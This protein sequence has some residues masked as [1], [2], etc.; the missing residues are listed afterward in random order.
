MNKFCVYCGEKLNSA[1][2][3]CGKCGKAIN[4]LSNSPKNNNILSILGLVFAIISAIFLVIFIA[5]PETESGIEILF[6]IFSGLLSVCG[7]VLS[8]V[9]FSKSKK[10]SDYKRIIS[11]IAMIVNITLFS[12]IIFIFVIVFI[13]FLGDAIFNTGILED[14]LAMNI[15]PFILN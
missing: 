15:N 1:D 13:I 14:L 11:L 6:I 12:F 4:Q 3:F 2:K 5:I 10:G 7:I 8:F 9:S